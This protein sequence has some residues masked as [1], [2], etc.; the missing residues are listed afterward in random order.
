MRT[1]ALHAVPARPRVSGD[2]S[3]KNVFSLYDGLRENRINALARLLNQATQAGDQWEARR[4]QKEWKAAID[5]R[6]PMQTW[7][8]DEEDKA[9]LRALKK[10]RRQDSRKGSMSKT[11]KKAFANIKRKLEDIDPE[12]QTP[13]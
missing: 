5:A 7:L 9:R 13:F 3:G 10:A 6:S 2:E 12:D 8:I 1:A 4:I 11:A